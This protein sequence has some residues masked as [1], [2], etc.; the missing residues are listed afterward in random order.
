[1]SRRGDNMHGLRLHISIKVREEINPV[2]ALLDESLEA[3]IRYSCLI[4]GAAILD[5]FVTGALVQALRQ[6][7]LDLYALYSSYTSWLL[8][9][10]VKIGRGSCP[11]VR[12]TLC[13]DI[14]YD[15]SNGA[16]TISADCDKIAYRCYLAY[17][18][19]VTA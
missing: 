7:F 8:V 13:D 12:S 1:M 11:I 10:E 9:D 14:S 4:C 2:L 18:D 15:F 16:L 5:K 19:D 6:V 17:R 3:F